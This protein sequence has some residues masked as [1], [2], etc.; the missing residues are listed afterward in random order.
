MPDHGPLDTVPPAG[1]WEFSLKEVELART[2]KTGGRSTGV[3]A[4]GGT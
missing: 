2:V 1:R 4:G 3:T